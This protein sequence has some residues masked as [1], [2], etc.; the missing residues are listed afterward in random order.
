MVDAYGQTYSVFVYFICLF[1][2]GRFYGIIPGGSHLLS[3]PEGV[4]GG[5]RLPHCIL[6]MYVVHYIHYWDVG[7][8]SMQTF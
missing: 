2:T 7:R 5:S 1:L 6:R 8:E 3:Y 4:C